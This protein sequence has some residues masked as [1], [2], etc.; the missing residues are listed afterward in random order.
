MKLSTRVRY[1]LRGLFDIAYHGQGEPVQ[2]KAIA[3]RQR[4]TPRYLEQIFHVLKKAGLLE[5]VRGPSGGYRLALDPAQISLGDLIRAADGPIDFDPKERAPSSLPSSGGAG[6]A[7]PEDQGALFLQGVW[8]GL[9]EEVAGIF[10]QLTLATL[11]ERAKAA[12]LR[13]ASEG[14]ALMYFI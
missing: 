1:G 9:S 8:E 12:E 2:L 11:C 6:A 3:K 10:D 14:K 13:R 4:V 7:L 5:A